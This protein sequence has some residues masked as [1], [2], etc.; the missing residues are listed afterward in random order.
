MKTY[1]LSKQETSD[2]M[3]KMAANWVLERHNDGKLTFHNWIIDFIKNAL[4]TRTFTRDFLEVE[5]SYLSS[6]EIQDVLERVKE[7]VSTNDTL[8]PLDYKQGIFL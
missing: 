1:L 6:D 5:L 2:L 7:Y 4:D 8:L 3:F